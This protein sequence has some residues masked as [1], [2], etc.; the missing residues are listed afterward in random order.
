MKS[1][2]IL[3]ASGALAA[4]L[5][6]AFFFEQA[7]NAQAV[8]NP[9]TPAAQTTPT[10]VCFEIHLYQVGI[11]DH[12]YDVLLNKCTGDSWRFDHGWESEASVSN[13]YGGRQA[14]DPNWIRMEKN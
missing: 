14:R 2:I 1:R 4:I 10:G 9:S 8:R 12:S 11:K 6:M 13:L 3:C 5:L 7:V